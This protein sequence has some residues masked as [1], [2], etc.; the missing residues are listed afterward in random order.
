MKRSVFVS[1]A[2][3]ALLLAGALAKADTMSG[4]MAMPPPSVKAGGNVG[5]LASSLQGRPVVV[6]VHADWCPV[7][8]AE[9][10]TLESLR[11]KYGER[12]AF[13]V[14]DVTNA[15]AADAAAAKAKQLG[16]GAFF[17]AHKAQT[18]TVGVINPKT[19][20]VAATLYNVT[21]TPEYAKPIDAVAKKLH[22]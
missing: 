11:S 22:S 7:C 18:G 2:V 13:V 16:L 20:A 17:D 9:Q 8:K 12:V 10:A 21:G 6:Q 1:A 15:K 3:A 14:L 4:D 5:M 19:G